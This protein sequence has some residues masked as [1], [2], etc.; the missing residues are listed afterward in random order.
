[1]KE[2]VE[3][4]IKKKILFKSLKEVEKT[5][6]GTRKKLSIYISTD[7]K[8]NYHS[9][10]IVKQKS[11]FLLKNAI[12]LFELEGKLQELEKHN[13]KYKHLLITTELCSKASLYLK[14][15]GWK[16]DFM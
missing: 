11:R 3:F 6:L 12:E 7:N 9:I 5:L 14:Q 10:F 2:L 16:I 4:F 8:A 1:L 15:R 13:F